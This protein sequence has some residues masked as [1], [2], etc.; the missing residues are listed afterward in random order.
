MAALVES[1]IALGPEA[2]DGMIALFA[3]LDDDLFAILGLVLG[4]AWRDPSDPRI[5]VQ[6]ARLKLLEPRSFTHRGVP[7]GGWLWRTSN[8]DMR[9]ELWRSLARGLLVTPNLRELAE[10]LGVAG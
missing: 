4:A 5:R 8:F 9:Y 2:V 10:L 6:I 1:C 3:A 7:A